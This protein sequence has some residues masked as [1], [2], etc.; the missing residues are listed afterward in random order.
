MDFLSEPL[1][2]CLGIPVDLD[3]CVFAAARVAGW[4][5]HVIEQYRDATL[6]RP[7]AR[8]AGAPDR[9]FSSR[10]HASRSAPRSVEAGIT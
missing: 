5:A 2:Y 3:T 7:K 10:T 4:V 6:I 1:L 9:A 8:Y